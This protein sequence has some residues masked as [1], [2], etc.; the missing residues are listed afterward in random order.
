MNSLGLEIFAGLIGILMGFLYAVSGFTDPGKV[1]EF[2]KNPRVKNLI[3]LLGG[4]GGVFLLDW[5]IMAPEDVDAHL[6]GALMF[7]YALCAIGAAIIVILGMSCFIFLSTE[8]LA[9]RNPCLI[10]RSGDLV[11]EYISYGYR[12]YRT[13]QEKLEAAG[14]AGGG[15]PEALSAVGSTLSV[16]ISATARDRGRGDPVQRDLLIDQALL[17]IES[18]VKLFATGVPNL[19]LRTNYMAVAP[20]VRL[21][22]TRQRFVADAPQPDTKFLVLRRYRDQLAEAFA[23]PI[24]AVSEKQLP[25]APIAAADGQACLLNPKRLS[26]RKG[27]PKATRD[28]VKAFFKGA[29]YGSVLSV[30][31]I[32]ERDVVGVVN[33]ESNHIDLVGKGSDMSRRIGIALAPFCVVLGELVRRAEE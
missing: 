10:G 21:G 13:R 15:G 25:G 4:A 11:L 7:S 17:A 22:T 16:L 1:E 2:S 23:I 27:V 20:F 6:R 28:Q 26:F 18:T 33:V 12:A 31:L 5:K 30:P 32:W 19:E 14:E 3:W 9:R 24:A 29:G 8:G